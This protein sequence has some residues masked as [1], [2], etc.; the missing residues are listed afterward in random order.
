MLPRPQPRILGAM[1]CNVVSLIS[2]S[3]PN[4][5]SRR[6]QKYSCRPTA[7]CIFE[8]KSENGELSIFSFSFSVQI[9]LSRWSTPQTGGD[10]VPWCRAALVGKRPEGP[11]DQGAQ[12][13]QGCNGWHSRGPR[14]HGA[15]PR[16]TKGASAGTRQD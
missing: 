9:S 11:S 7:A 6:M 1:A 10:C 13:E 12:E 15:T 16:R 3:L 4:L 8:I 2:K 5:Y 14:S